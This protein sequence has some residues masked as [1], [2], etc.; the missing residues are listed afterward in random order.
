MVY[1]EPKYVYKGTEPDITGKWE[2]IYTTKAGIT[3]LLQNEKGQKLT[4]GRS[5]LLSQF[6]EVQIKDWVSNTLL[7]NSYELRSVVG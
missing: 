2:I 4:V 6:K 7:T 3:F 1:K 5:C